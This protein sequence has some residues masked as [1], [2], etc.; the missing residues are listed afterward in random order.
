MEDVEDEITQLLKNILALNEND[1]MVLSTQLKELCGQSESDFKKTISDYKYIFVADN[2]G[3]NERNT[4]YDEKCEYLSNGNTKTN[5]ENFIKKY[6]GIKREECLILN[7][8]LISTD[9]TTDLGKKVPNGDKSQKLI[10]ELVVKI[11]KEN[12]ECHT[13]L[14]GW[15][16]FYEIDRKAIF[17]KF[18]KKLDDLLKNNQEIENRMLAFPHPS[19]RQ[20]FTKKEQEQINNSKCKDEKD[21]FFKFV[22]RKQFEDRKSRKIEYYLEEYN[23]KK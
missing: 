4:K 16:D 13:V 15:T 7:K 6:L 22:G 2:P 19:R 18:Y 21:D 23:Q 11:M 8:S 17:Q 3:K 9:S 10:A 1:N 14:M 5:F 12:L 20:L